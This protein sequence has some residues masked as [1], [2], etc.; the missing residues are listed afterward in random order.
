M[1]GAK[2]V[3][4]GNFIRVTTPAISND[5]AAHVSSVSLERQDFISSMYMYCMY[6]VLVIYVFCI[7]Y[8]RECINQDPDVFD[9]TLR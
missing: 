4:I 6:I 3:P 2:Y 1:S 9:S 7:L 5:P 8:Q